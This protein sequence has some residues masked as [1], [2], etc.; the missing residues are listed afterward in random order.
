MRK[1]WIRRGSIDTEPAQSPAGY[2]LLRVSSNQPE[3]R[4]PAAM[5][6]RLHVRLVGDFE[7]S[8]PRW[9]KLPEDWDFNRLDRVP[10]DGWVPMGDGE[11]CRASAIIEAQLMS[12]DEPVPPLPP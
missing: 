6:K 5:A 10:A 8:W 3:G 4:S 7:G 9:R 11:W 2:P 1:C 12:E